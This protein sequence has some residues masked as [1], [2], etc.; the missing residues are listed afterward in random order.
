MR[1]A[2]RLL[3]WFP[4]WAFGSADTF[5]GLAIGAAQVWPAVKTWDE[6]ERDQVF[7]TMSEPVFWLIALMA[8]GLW[9]YLTWLTWPSRDGLKRWPPHPAITQPMKSPYGTAHLTPARQ[10][11]IGTDHFFEEVNRG[12]RRA[13]QAHPGLEKAK[14]DFWTQDREPLRNVS[15]SRL[16]AGRSTPAGGSPTMSS[17][18]SPR[19][20]TKRITGSFCRNSWSLPATES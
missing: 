9:A 18:K 16:L 14:R 2:H 5:V 1:L 8:G 13:G 7:V 19:S 11:E 20:A 15:L 10:R 3:C 6:A 4:L 17:S 12:V